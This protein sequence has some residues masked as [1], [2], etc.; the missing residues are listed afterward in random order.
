MVGITVS[1]LQDVYHYYAYMGLQLDIFLH[2]KGR[3]DMYPYHEH[4]ILVL[5]PL[6]HRK[7]RCHLGEES[8]VG[9]KLGAW[10]AMGLWAHWDLAGVTDLCYANE[11]KLQCFV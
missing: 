1:L 5:D 4:V 7:A 6:L 11:K 9:L 8:G 2:R 3:Q 10:A